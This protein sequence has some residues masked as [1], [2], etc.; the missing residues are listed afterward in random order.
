LV[1][2]IDPAGGSYYV[3]SLTAELGERAWKLFQEVEKLGGMEA[4]LRAGFPQTTIATTAAE[5]LEGAARRRDSI[6]G[7][8]QYANPKERPLERLAID[9]SAFHKRRVQQVL[10]Y[11]TSLEE[12]QSEL[13][14]QKLA[15]VVDSKG[16]ATFEACVDAV[17]S[18]ATLGEITRATRISDGPCAPITPVYLARVSQKYE[19]LRTAAQMNAARTG[20]CPKAF[21]CSMGSLRDFKARADFSR[22]FLSAGGYEVIY[23]E[24]LKTPEDAAEAFDKSGARLAVICSKDSNYPQLVPLLVLALRA[25]RADAVVLLAGYPPEH[26]EAFKKAG[27]DDFIHIRAD[28]VETLNNLHKR[29]GI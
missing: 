14:M 24:A 3:E 21:L 26:L 15:K 20:E 25:R 2:P 19:Q 10:S 22:G 9:T 13:V 1:Q 17:V 5:K 28:V 27:V 18:G 6:V 4:A 8:N 7:V 23:P 12:D 29:L 11:R 16:T